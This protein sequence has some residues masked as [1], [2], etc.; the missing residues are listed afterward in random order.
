MYL[1][2]ALPIGVSVYLEISNHQEEENFRNNSKLERSFRLFRGIE[3]VR[4]PLPSREVFIAYASN[5]KGTF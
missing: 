3:P 5:Y 1:T 4:G 2:A